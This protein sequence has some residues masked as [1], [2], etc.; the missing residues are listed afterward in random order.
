MNISIYTCST[1]VYIYMIIHIQLCINKQVI[2]MNMY[3]DNIS[4]S[5]IG[6]VVATPIYL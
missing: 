5:D 6:T 2:E 4:Y 3:T 1:Y